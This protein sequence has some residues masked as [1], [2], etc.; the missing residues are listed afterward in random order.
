MTYL[1]PSYDGLK[2][3]KPKKASNF[4]PGFPKVVPVSSLPDQ[5]RSI[6]EGSYPKVVAVAPGAWAG[7]PPGASVK[8]VANGDILEATAPP[9]RHTS[10]STPRGGSTEAVF[11]QAPPA[12][13]TL[14]GKSGGTPRPGLLIP[15][16]DRR[17]TETAGLQPAAILSS[18]GQK[19][20]PST[21]WRRG[22]LV[23]RSVPGSRDNRPKY[24]LVVAIHGA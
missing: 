14:G 24:G 2:P 20:A 10:G 11:L 16:P 6:F 22:K 23:S 21:G 18:R 8:D 12:R 5:P 19:Y 1:C 15:R 13:Q 17:P 4:P 7:L 9:S 3:P